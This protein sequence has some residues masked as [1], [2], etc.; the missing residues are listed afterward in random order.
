[1]D[2]LDI[3][4]RRFSL[5]GEIGVYM[6]IKAVEEVDDATCADASNGNPFN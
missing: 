3:L 6:L 2:V 1:M 5:T 4:W